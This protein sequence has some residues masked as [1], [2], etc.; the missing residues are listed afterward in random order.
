MPYVL[1]VDIGSSN[2]S[3]A[4][5]RRDG[6]GWAES[7]AGGGATGRPVATIVQLGA[8]SNAVESVLEVA[9]DGSLVPRDGT[10]R[11]G[12]PAPGRADWS[13]S[14]FIRRV[15]DDVPLV[16]GG[17]PFPAHELT[18]AMIRWIVDRVWAL[19]AEPP[20]QVVLA[21]PAGWGPYRDGLLRGALHDAG[22]GDVVLVAAALAAAAGHTAGNT[23]GG[24][25]NGTLPAS[26]VFAGYDLGGTGFTG[27]V[28]E[29]HSGGGLELVGFVERPVGGADLDDA[30]VA[31]VQAR[32]GVSTGARR[33]KP[34]AATMSWLR[35]S[36]AAARE[37]LSDATEAVVV[38]PTPGKQPDA[39]N[40]GQVDV[41]VTRDELAELARPLLQPTVDSLV[42][43]V[44]ESGD[45]AA[46]L[47]SGGATRTPGIVELISANLPG[48]V[49]VDPEPETIVARGAALAARRVLARALHGEPALSRRRA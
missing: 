8:R 16:T 24:A 5:C 26:G 34:D 4:I 39:S 9:A 14:G 20:E 23:A 15:G 42:Q 37:R 32:A 35:S 21:C 27:S 11:S 38:V 22:L 46:V 43:L 49:V 30:L 13:I 29:K 28:V 36:C 7:G 31:H 2:A 44:R 41:V 17:Q 10:G 18:A 19:E 40:G 48:P 3:A 12:P 47:V 33:P 6:E 45:P 25:A 1:G